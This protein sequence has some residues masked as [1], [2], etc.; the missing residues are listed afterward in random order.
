MQCSPGCLHVSSCWEQGS[1]PRLQVQPT[2]SLQHDK[3]RLAP[4]P[5]HSCS[6]SCFAK[7]FAAR[8]GQPCVNSVSID[9]VENQHQTRCPT[10]G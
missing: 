5:C 4:V 9:H 3:T 2:Q 10:S 1:Q 6:V 7:A 8:D